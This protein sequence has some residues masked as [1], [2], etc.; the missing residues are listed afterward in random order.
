VDF[1]PTILRLKEAMNE[2]NDISM[3]VDLLIDVLES[4]VIK[5]ICSVLNCSY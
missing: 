3:V 4:N 2:A 5:V 1:L